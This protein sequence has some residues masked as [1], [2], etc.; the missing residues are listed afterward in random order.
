MTTVPDLPSYRRALRAVDAVVTTV[1]GD[2]WDHPSPCDG[3]TAADVLGHL[4]TGQT[5]LAG[6]AS[7][8]AWPTPG[9]A[10][11]PPRR[12][13]D[14]DPAAGWR[15]ARDASPAG[16]ADG[17]LR[18]PVTTPVGTTTLPDFLD[19]LAV[20]E[21]LVHAWDLASAVGADAA[22]PADPMVSATATRRPATHPATHLATHLARVPAGTP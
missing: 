15:A 3:W 16:L 6:L 9:S 22:L 7:G 17:D 5:A 4:A 21:L 18:R 12:V 2:A 20:V 13:L 10:P 19:R 14:A 11:E 8:R 1:P